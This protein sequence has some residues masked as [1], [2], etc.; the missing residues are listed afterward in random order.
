MFLPPAYDWFGFLSQCK[1]TP[2]AITVG[3]IANNGDVK[4]IANNKLSRI[5]LLFL[6]VFTA[7]NY[8]CDRFVYLAIY[9]ATET[10]V[11]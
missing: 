1:L 4:Y 11:R 7:V 9:L 2:S 6:F 3:N 5:S 8:L 10:Q